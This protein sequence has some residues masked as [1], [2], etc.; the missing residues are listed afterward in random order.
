MWQGGSDYLAAYRVSVDGALPDTLHAIRSQ[1]ARQTWTALEVAGEPTSY[2]VAAACAFRTEAQ[3]G[4][5]AP[6]AGLTAE[7]GNQ[8]PALMALDLLST[9]RLDGHTAAPADLLLRLNWPTPP[10]GA[11]RAP[12]TEA[13][14]RT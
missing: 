8:L 10:T 9:Q 13:A 14:T 7:R 1:P 5:T 6:L 11:H 12:L 3:P 4:G 2:T